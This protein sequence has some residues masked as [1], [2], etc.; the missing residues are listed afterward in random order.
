MQYL[1]AV[2]E[3]HQVEKELNEWV[4]REGEGGGE[5]GKDGGCVWRLFPVPFRQFA[6]TSEIQNKTKS[7]RLK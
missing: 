5:G 2:E 4:W 3:Q 7:G 1:R 6:E